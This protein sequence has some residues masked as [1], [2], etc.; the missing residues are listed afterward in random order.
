ML[1]N[2]TVWKFVQEED[3]KVDK[4]YIHITYQL[5]DLSTCY[6]IN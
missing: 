3:K 6:Y 1:I 2:V 5:I 4:L